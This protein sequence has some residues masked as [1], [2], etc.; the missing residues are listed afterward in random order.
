MWL[1]TIHWAQQNRKEEKNMRKRF[2]ATT[3]TMAMC[4]SLFA[5]CSSGSGSSS[6]SGSSASGGDVTFTIGYS[7]E[8]P[9]MDPKDFNTT[10]CTLIGYD[11]YDTLLNF[12]MDGSELEPCIAESW[13]QVDDTTYTYK[14]RDDIKFSDGN[15]MTMDD[16]LFSMER[17]KNDAYSMSYLFDSVD[18]F[19]VDAD[20]WTLTVYLK[21]PNATWKFVPATSPCTIVEKAVVEKEGDDYGQLTG[22]VVGTGPYMLDKW[23]SGTEITLKK[24]PY[25]WNDPDSLDV[26]K[27]VYEVIEDDT[28]RALAAQSGQIDYARNLT[29]DTLPTYESAQNMTINAYDGTTANYLAYNCEK[30]P[31]DDANARKAI[32]YCIDKEAYTSL[33]G[34]KYATAKKSLFI[35]SSMYEIDKDAWN[36]EDESLE[37]YQ[38]DY[39]KAKECLAASKYPDGFE[40]NLYTSATYKTGA[41]AIQNMIKE[42]GLPITVNIVEYQNSDSFSISYGYTTDDDGHRVYDALM[43]GWVSDWL[44][45]TGYM[46]NCLYGKSNYAGGANK[47]AYSSD[48]FDDLLHQSY[49]TSDDAQRSELMLNAMKIAVEDCPVDTLY[50][51]KDTY[52]INDKFEYEEGPNFFWNFSVANVH[53]KK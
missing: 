15:A 8:P 27:V 39:A 37:S 20:T 22:S 51:T 45:P 14:I 11:C 35:P 50:E 44:D 42:S 24:N 53:L 3:L 38:Q 21:E 13:E 52:I 41:E 40:F 49:L 32:S 36:E 1:V 9:S 47:S 19:E 17:V 10:A 4:A 16:V 12:A 23:E 7:M 29:T 28:S 26:D 18:H 33:I 5:G 30:A 31:F 46:A 43:T 48:Q 6:Q 25:Y 34:G 2:I